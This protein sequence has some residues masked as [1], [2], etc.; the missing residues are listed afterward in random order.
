MVGESESKSPGINL[1]SPETK[2][3]GLSILRLNID[4]TLESDPEL[5]WKIVMINTAAG[6]VNAFNIHMSSDKSQPLSIDRKTELSKKLKP[7]RPLIIL[8]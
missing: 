1:R 7:I 6:V 4:P 2:P 8:L 5:A 3:N